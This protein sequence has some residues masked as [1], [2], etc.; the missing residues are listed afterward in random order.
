MTVILKYTCLLF[1]VIPFTQVLLKKKTY[2]QFRE[3]SKL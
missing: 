3:V 1:N 2:K